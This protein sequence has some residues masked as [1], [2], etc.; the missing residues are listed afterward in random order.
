M[1]FQL[2]RRLGAVLHFPV[3][4]DS[5]HCLLADL[6]SALLLEHA[7]LST[8]AEDDHGLGSALHALY[9]LRSQCALCVVSRSW[10]PSAA[11]LGAG[12]VN[13]HHVR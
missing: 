2:K 8:S 13:S 10:K 12:T 9:A 11:L 7:I 1:F 3:R 6:F 4:C 5:E